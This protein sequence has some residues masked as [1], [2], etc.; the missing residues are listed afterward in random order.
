MLTRAYPSEGA[1]MHRVV[2]GLV[3]VMLAVVA[4]SSPAAGWSQEDNPDQGGPC[5]PCVKWSN[6]FNGQYFLK[7]GIQRHPAWAPWIGED[8]AKWNAVPSAANPTWSR[9]TNPDSSPRLQLDQISIGGL[10]GKAYFYWGSGSILYDSSANLNTNVSYGGRNGTV[11]DC[12]FDFTVLHEVGHT[13]GLGHSQYWYSVMKA[14]DNGMTT[15]DSDD[16]AGIQYIY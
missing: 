13:E 1:R 7:G 3:A 15:L 6:G 9:T 2:L 11:G 8:I 4:S 14:N 16:I 12:N 5:S 10:C